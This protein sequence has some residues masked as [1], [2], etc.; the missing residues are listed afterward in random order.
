MFPGWGKRRADQPRQEFPQLHTGDFVWSIRNH[1]VT[2]S[3]TGLD[4]KKPQ[5]SPSSTPCHGHGHL[6]LTT[7]FRF[8]FLKPDCCQT[9]PCFHILCGIFSTELLSNCS[10]SLPWKLTC[11]CWK[12]N[13][14]MSL[15]SRWNEL[16]ILYGGVSTN[17]ATGESSLE[18][19][20]L[21]ADWPELKMAGKVL[22]KC[23]AHQNQGNQP[24]APCCPWLPPKN[25]NKI[26]EVIKFLT[27][28]DG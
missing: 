16:D 5:T 2:E 3:Q 18:H 24:G 11:S 7:W 12:R 26:P 20:C 22:T 10:L 23:F 9:C 25:C 21:S 4:W 27:L 14:K 15:E 17:Q 1:R 6:P 28:A 13:L 19:W 8:W